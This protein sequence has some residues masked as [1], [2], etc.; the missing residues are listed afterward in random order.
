[1]GAIN[2][3]NSLPAMSGITPGLSGGWYY[4]GSL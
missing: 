4:G 1:L 2:T 3:Q